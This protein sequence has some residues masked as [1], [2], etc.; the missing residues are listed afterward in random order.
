MHDFISTPPPSPEHSVNEIICRYPSVLSVLDGFGVDT[1][2]G[3][4]ESLASAAR[5]AR[6]PIDALM[7]GISAAIERTFASTASP[8]SAG[9]NSAASATAH[10]TV[11]VERRARR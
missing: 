10:E 3:G 7:A 1:C 6:I 5:S 8:A 2:C 4:A 9:C 11:T